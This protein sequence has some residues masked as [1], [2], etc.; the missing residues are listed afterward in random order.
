MAVSDYNNLRNILRTNARDKYSVQWS[1]TALDNIIND[2]QREYSFYAQNLVGEFEIKS[3]VSGLL[4]LPEDFISPI[5]A[6]SNEGR[7]IPIVSWRELVK[8]YGDF[9][10]VKGEKAQCLCLD[11]DGMP[12]IRIFPVIPAGKTVGQL[13]YVRYAKKDI[14]EI[15]NIEALKEHCLFQMSFVTANGKYQAHYSNFLRLVDEEVR[16]NH[17]LNIRKRIRTG[18][19]Y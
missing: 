3:S 9:R 6:I 19:F 2:A 8:S 4:L 18:V 1:D 14:P 11:F 10:K 7:E 15:K 17:T 16:S 13:K 12:K 5:K